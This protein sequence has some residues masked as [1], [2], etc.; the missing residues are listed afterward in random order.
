MR[1]HVR[2]ED[3]QVCKADSRGRVYLGPEYADAEIEVA[4]LD[5]REDADE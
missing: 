4:V 1:V 2:P 3:V 5:Q